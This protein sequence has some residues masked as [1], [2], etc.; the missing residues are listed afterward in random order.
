MILLL[1]FRSLSITASVSRFSHSL[2]ILLA[3][4]LNYCFFSKNTISA[5]VQYIIWSGDSKDE[6]NITEILNYESD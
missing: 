1:V 4:I 3:E 5:W 6:Q 2:Q